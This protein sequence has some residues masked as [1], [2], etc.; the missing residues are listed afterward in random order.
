MASA[1]D[2]T[3][4]EEE[5]EEEGGREDVNEACDC[6]TDVL[7]GHIQPQLYMT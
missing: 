2:V 6:T 3:W 5:E 4:K 7:M 1:R